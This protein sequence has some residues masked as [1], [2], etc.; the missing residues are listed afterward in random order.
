MPLMSVS[1]D[2]GMIVLIRTGPRGARHAVGECVQAH[3]RCEVGELVRRG[4]DRTDAR[5]MLMIDPLRSSPPAPSRWPTFYLAPIVANVEDKAPEVLDTSRQST[6]GPSAIAIAL[7]R[8]RVG[9]HD[10]T[11]RGTTS[12]HRIE[13]RMFQIDVDDLVA[14]IS[15]APSR[16]TEQATPRSRHRRPIGSRR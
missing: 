16:S 6:A 11:E 14:A 3:L 4:G 12:A 13:I 15:L 2:R 5:E 7:A 9:R 10:N 1:N 8:I